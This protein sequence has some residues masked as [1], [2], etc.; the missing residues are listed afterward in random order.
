MIRRFLPPPF[1]SGA[2]GTEDF[3]EQG[4][5][6]AACKYACAAEYARCSATYSEHGLLSTIELNEAQCRLKLSEAPQAAEP[7]SL[8]S[9]S[10]RPH[11]ALTSPS[12][13]PHLA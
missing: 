4:W 1:A 13:R 7:C 9:P 3:K 8:T 10:P 2:K 5:R 11:L 12:P 6:A